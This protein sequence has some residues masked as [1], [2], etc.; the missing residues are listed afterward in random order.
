MTTYKTKIL[1]A[2][3]VA[4]GQG[5]VREF[6]MDTYILRHFKWI[7]NKDLLYC[8]MLCGS[9]DGR[10]AGGECIHGYMENVCMYG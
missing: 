10:G 1:N 7:T 8:S 4:R 2:R 9:L 5:R 3:V 6:G